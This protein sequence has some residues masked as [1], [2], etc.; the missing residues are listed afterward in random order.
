M[1]FKLKKYTGLKSLL[2]DVPITNAT[3]QIFQIPQQLTL[4]GKILVALE[5]YCATNGGTFPPNAVFIPKSVLSG[6]VLIDYDDLCNCAIILKD[7]NNTNLLDSLPLVD[8]MTSLNY[9]LLK[10][11]DDYADGIWNVSWP[12]SQLKF[13]NGYTVTTGANGSALFTAWYVDPEDLQQ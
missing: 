1:A 4:N 9:G 11:F 3:T 8:L 2:I 5:T 6:R 12:N 7:V 10:R 13:V